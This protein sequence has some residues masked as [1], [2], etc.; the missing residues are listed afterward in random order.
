MDK[1]ENAEVPDPQDFTDESP[2]PDQDRQLARLCNTLRKRGVSRVLIGYEGS[3]DSGCVANIDCEPE[4]VSLSSF[5]RAKLGEVAEGYC[6]EG[7]E[8]ND[9]GYGTLTL[10]LSQGLAELE[11]TDRF[12][13]TEAM[14]TDA[15]RLPGALRRRLT[16]RGVRSITVEFDGY[17]D[18]GQ[19][20][21]ID[22]LPDSISL[23][24]KV[25]D[26]LQDRLL[27]HLPGG[28]EIN[29]GGFGSFTVDVQSGEVAVD[30]SYR[31]EKPE[32][33]VTR[34]HWRK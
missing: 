1:S 13:D 9:G 23:D 20:T 30:A 34:W 25:R 18:S 10:Y 15:V 2:N 14:D 7:Y 33:R 32:T 11:H 22:V 31:I 12:E 16:L 6:P 8:T 5:V 24:E 21:N 17:G 29:E 26:E 28:W 27:D 19:I 4:S 3:G